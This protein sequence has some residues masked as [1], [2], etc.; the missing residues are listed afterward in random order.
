MAKRG[1]IIVAGGS[2]RRMQSSLPKQFMILGNEPVVARTINTFAEVLPGAEIVVV[3]PAE[4]IELWRSL[5]AR[6]DVAVHKC[7]AGGKE[8]F[9]SVKRGIEALSSEVEFIAVH[10]G[11][12]AL[13]SKKLI[14]RTVLAADEH[15]AVIPVVNVTDSI[16]RVEGEESFIV[17]RSELRAVQTPQVFRAELLRRAY[18]LPYDPR[19][20]DDA[21]VVEMAGGRIAL[22]EGERSNL[23]L[24]TPEDMAWAEWWL[25]QPNN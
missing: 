14:L 7:V 4:H 6:F 1:I 12:R 19:F 23:K 20:T 3:L 17:P 21:S 11:V 24:T 10:D 2:G 5:V 15:D 18:A 25:S 22:V 13:V 9:D 8:R 16:R